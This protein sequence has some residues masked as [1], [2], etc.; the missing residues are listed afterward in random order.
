MQQPLRTWKTT[1]QNGDTSS[2]SPSKRELARLHPKDGVSVLKTGSSDSDSDDDSR[3]M[4]SNQ[5]TLNKMG[6]SIFASVLNLA[7]T[8]MGAGLLGI[9]TRFCTFPHFHISDATD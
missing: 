9:C 6:S 5:V 2:S 1:Y 3:M 7:N 8:V 4:S